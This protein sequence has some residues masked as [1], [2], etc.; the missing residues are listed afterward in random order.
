MSIVY[1]GLFERV[2]EW[3]LAHIMEPVYKF[4]AN[5]LTTVFTWVFQEILAPILMPILKEVLYFAIDLWKTIYCVQLYNLFSSVLKLIDYLQTAFDVFIGV[6]D[7]TY[8]ESGG[9]QVTGSLL[10]VLIQQ[11]TISTVFW[12]LTLGGLGLALILTIYA[13]AKSAFDLDF[14]NRRP[15]SKVLASMMKTFIQFFTVPFLVYFL[16]KL[17]A[18]ILRGVT[19]ILNFGTETT[20]GRIVFVIASLDA[21][22]DEAYNLST[23]ASG[24]V[25][26]TSSD[27]IIRY[28]FYS[29]GATGYKIRDYGDIS[30]VSNYFNLADFDYLIGFLAAV[31]LLFTIGVCL[32]VF[33]QRIFELLLL[34]LVSP[35][36]VCTMPLDDGEK[37][38][39]W[40]EMFVGKCFTGFGSAIGMRLYLMVCPMVMGNTIRFGTSSSPEMDYMMKLF[41]LA[42]G[43]WAVYK[44]GP[45]I[46][47]LLSFQ[48]AQSES[49]TS[50]MAGGFLFSQTAG[51]AIGYGR[52]LMAGGLSK[53][54]GKAGA[55]KDGKEGAAA[56]GSQ[57]F[58]GTRGGAGKWSPGGVKTG[59]AK[60]LSGDFI[61]KPKIG[62]GYKRSNIVMGGHRASG[63]AGTKTGGATLSGA[64]SK[65]K[66]DGAKGLSGGFIG[67][68]KIGEGYKRSGIVMGGHRTSGSGETESG[69]AAAGTKGLSG[70]FIGTPKI[71][72]GYQRSGIV[73]GGHRAGGTSAA[74]SAGADENQ[75]Y[76]HNFSIGSLFSNTYDDK[77]NRTFRMFGMGFTA[78]HEGR[79]TS[80]TLPCLS[81]Q[82]GEGSERLQVSRARL[83]G[84]ASYHANL[85]DKG[86]M[87]FSDLNVLG[88]R[89]ASN[90]DGTGSGSISFMGGRMSL[91]RGSDGTMSHFKV[92]A[93]QVTNDESGFDVGLGNRVGVRSGAE[94][95]NVGFGNRVQVQTSHGQGLSGF[96]VGSINYSRA[97]IKRETPAGGTAAPQGKVSVR[98]TAAGKSPTGN[99]K[100]PGGSKA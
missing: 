82:R 16:L 19:N 84:I 11:K 40:R 86:K 81:L 78:D 31:F 4:V 3:V 6:R 95:V 17:A 8:T 77:G 79:T 33:V 28:P 15:V 80:V 51:R 32:I 71:G 64:A 91:G 76:H 70:A 13:T 87:R 14:E 10:E 100:T 99:T 20:L 54:G 45:M 18:V 65:A 38:S 97:G 42:G 7:V 96:Q 83:P 25:L 94:G 88:M 36:F 62:A 66:A 52:R 92:G 29:L 12:A 49:M 48:A 74:A 89:C 55:G 50:A 56:G 30:T 93:F 9:A 59:G 98:G 47:S 75:R 67:T 43:A 44:S 37:F 69:S 35:Y 23:A 26:G 34:Y 61:G 27:D 1:L 21:A 60:G 57:R 41:F 53:S 63:G 39:K 85:D 68:P 46:T 22:K 73:M 90:Q 58:Q 72:E 5:L 2:F 24:L